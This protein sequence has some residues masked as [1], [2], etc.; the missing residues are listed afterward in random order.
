MH[1]PTWI[2]WANL[3]PFSLQTVP[4]ELGH[5][6]REP[7]AVDLAAGESVIKKVPISTERAQIYIR[8]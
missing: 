8:P 3:T 7:E 4:E 1:G 2:F 5:L 6:Y